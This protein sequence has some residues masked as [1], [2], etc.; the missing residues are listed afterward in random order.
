MNKPSVNDSPPADFA[1]S[2]AAA[3]EE[4]WAGIREDDDPA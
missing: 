4:Q 3:L 2:I 1:E